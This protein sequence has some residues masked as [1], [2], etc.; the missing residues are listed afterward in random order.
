MLVDGHIRRPLTFQRGEEEVSPIG[1]DVEKWVLEG[2]K[3]VG[4]I[5]RHF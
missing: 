1:L 2:E 5:G 3:L 4:V